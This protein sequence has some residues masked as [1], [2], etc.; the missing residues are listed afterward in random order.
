MPCKGMPGGVRQCH[1]RAAP[2]SRAQ[3]RIAVGHWPLGQE[4]PKG[5]GGRG[6]E[7][8]TGP[9]AIYTREGRKERVRVSWEQY[10]HHIPQ[11]QR[12]AGRQRFEQPAQHLPSDRLGCGPIKER[13]VGG[14]GLTAGAWVAAS[15]ICRVAGR[16]GCTK[17]N[18]AGVERWAGRICSLWQR[19]QQRAER[20]LNCSVH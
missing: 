18:R 12:V 16:K 13:P 7:E 9:A 20:R 2:P 5:G 19:M 1:G 15:T 8:G 17:Q 14:G 4:G 3:A 10:T 6:G 11:V